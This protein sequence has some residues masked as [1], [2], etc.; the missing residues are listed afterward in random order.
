MVG[1]PP[2]AFWPL[3]TDRIRIDLFTPDDVDAMYAY[4]SLP[5]V[6]RYLYRPPHTRERSAQVIDTTAQGSPWSKAGHSLVLAVRRSEFPEP[7]GEIVLKLSDP[8]ARQVEIGWVFHPGYGGKGYATEAATAV[9]AAA[10]RALR[11]PRHPQCRLD[12]AVRAPGN[13]PRG[14]PDRQR[15]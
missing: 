11:P 14:A 4:Q 15:S 3:L 10:F 2:P 6:S 7:I 12:P 8:R 9:T 1:P 13:A 5:E